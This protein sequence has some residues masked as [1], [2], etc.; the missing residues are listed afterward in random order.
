MRLFSD[1]PSTRFETT[2]APRASPLQPHNA[3]PHGRQKYTARSQRP[4]TRRNRNREN[5]QRDRN[6]AIHLEIATVK[7]TAAARSQQRN[8]HRNRNSAVRGH[9]GNSKYPAGPTLTNAALHRRKR[10]YI[11]P[12]GHAQTTCTTHIATPHQEPTHNPP[13]RTCQSPGRVSRLSALPAEVPGI[14]SNLV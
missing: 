10:A 7:Y 8:T 6:G 5:T 1:S 13:H 14:N 3:Q 2:S 9:M 4:N 12:G 11:H